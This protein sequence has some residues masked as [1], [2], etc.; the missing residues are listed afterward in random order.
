[1]TRTFVDEG[2]GYYVQ[3]FL[4]QKGGYI[5]RKENIKHIMEQRLNCNMSIFTTDMIASLLNNLILS[6]DD[7][8]DT[9]IDNKQHMNTYSLTNYY[10]GDIDDDICYIDV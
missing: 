8:L 3:T 1:M 7:F 6:D 5:I 2:N 9:I 10:N 4:D